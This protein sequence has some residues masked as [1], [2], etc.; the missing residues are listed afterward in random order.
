M[1]TI[2]LRGV[3]TIYLRGCELAKLVA[4]VE[5][6]LAAGLTV[7]A[8]LTETKEWKVSISE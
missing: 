2:Y 5:Y 3:A 7:E 6:A 1:A 8:R 4:L